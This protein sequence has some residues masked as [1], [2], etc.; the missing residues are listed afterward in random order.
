[1]GRPCGCN[2]AAGS[3]PNSCDNLRCGGPPTRH[4]AGLALARP[5]PWRPDLNRCFE[6][7]GARAARAAPSAPGTL[8]R[9]PSGRREAAGDSETRATP[10]C[11]PVAAPQPPVWTRAAAA[12]LVVVAPSSN[13]QGRSRRRAAL[14]PAAPAWR[15]AI[16]RGLFSPSSGVK[17][18]KAGNRLGWIDEGSTKTRQAFFMY[19]YTR[20]RVVP[21]RYHV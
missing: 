17:G 5:R 13:A 11:Q 3:K 16:S 6:Q 10:G 2:L 12:V 15:R 14:R 4:W 20:A 21:P 18:G 7:A 8:P 19:S 1:M 9:G